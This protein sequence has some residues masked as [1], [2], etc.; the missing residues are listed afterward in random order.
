M[1]NRIVLI[2]RLVRD[3]DLRFTNN[4]VPVSNFTLAVE[5]SYTSKGGEK[6]VDFIR[7]I[8]WRK[9]A[10]TCAEHL[11]KGRLVAVDGSLHIQKKEKDGR[12]YVNA[13]VVGD[14]VRFLDWPKDNKNTEKSNND[15][16]K[17]EIDDSEFDVPF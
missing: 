8:V 16:G 2:G 17:S 7:I 3:V 14:N 9:L 13:E 5:R 4:G 15:Y 11:G 1:L 12:T 6:E 10:E